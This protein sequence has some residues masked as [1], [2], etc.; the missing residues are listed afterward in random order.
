[1]KLKVIE[2]L[3]TYCTWLSHKEFSNG[4][5][6]RNKKENVWNYANKYIKIVVKKKVSWSENL[7]TFWRGDI[8]LSF[9]LSWKINLWTVMF[10]LFHFVLLIVYST[11]KKI[12][13][14][15]FSFYILLY[16]IYR[17]CATSKFWHNKLFVRKKS[18]KS[19]SKTFH[20]ADII[21]MIWW[22]RQLC[23]R[24]RERK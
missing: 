23:Y 14:K 1:M 6:S 2:V 3:F 7:R 24:A 8:K 15:L 16:F 22:E 11:F 13:I 10:P 20:F 21:R 9:F 5:S 4:M 19:L 18:W 17:W 12:S